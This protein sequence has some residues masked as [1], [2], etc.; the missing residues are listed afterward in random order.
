M[1]YE[2]FHIDDEEGNIYLVSEELVKKAYK[3]GPKN[4]LK[5]VNFIGKKLDVW[6]S[7]PVLTAGN[8][9]KRV[10]HVLTRKSA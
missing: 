6:K 4:S 8:S 10:G 5:F 7:L 1:N 2:P 9:F 3:Q